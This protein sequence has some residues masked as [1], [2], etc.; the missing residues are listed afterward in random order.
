MTVE[1]AVR[2]IDGSRYSLS[3]TEFNLHQYSKYHSK[4]SKNMNN[5]QPK[6]RNYKTVTM[7]E[8]QMKEQL[9]E[10]SQKLYYKY[11]AQNMK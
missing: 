2:T 3:Q 6:F 10:T 4:I 11:T 1:H 5:P 8:I 9:I 7:I